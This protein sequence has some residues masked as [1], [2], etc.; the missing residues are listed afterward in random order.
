MYILTLLFHI[1]VDGCPT[2]ITGGSIWT[3]K[4]SS[5]TVTKRCRH[6]S[7]DF[8]RGT[9]TRFCDSNG[10]WSPIDYSDCRMNVANDFIYM[11]LVFTGIDR[12][13]IE[14]SLPNIQNQVC[15]LYFF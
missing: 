2:E 15:N 7:S 8:Y 1:S 14:S 9:A 10:K 4:S 13:T 11:W 5:T 3:S 12:S 6:L